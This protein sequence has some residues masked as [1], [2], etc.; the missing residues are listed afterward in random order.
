[1][2]VDLV[3]AFD[4]VTRW[5]SGTLAEELQKARND[6][7]WNHDVPGGLLSLADRLDVPQL[8]RTMVLVAEGSKSTGD[9]HDLLEIAASDT[10]AREKLARERRQEVSSYVAIVV[11]GFLV[12]LFVIV[13]VA[14]SFFGPI[15]EQAATVDASA[16]Q[17]PVSLA[18]IPVDAY[19]LLFLHSA[20]VQGFGSGLLAGKLAENDALSGLKYSL[21]LTVLTVV[22]FGVFV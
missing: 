10:R 6:I 14:A 20:L 11:L 8:T 2:G 4:L 1:M 9:L 13:L 7:A 19:Q 17:G 12:Y 18:A 5:A 3:E 15:A 16:A 21:A 22:I